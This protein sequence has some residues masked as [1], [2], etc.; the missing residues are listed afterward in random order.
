MLRIPESLHYLVSVRKSGHENSSQL[1]LPSFL[2]T[3][4]TPPSRVPR[5]ETAYML[6]EE[7]FERGF[8]GG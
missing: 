7:H 3:V 6:T 1:V 5:N 4:Y 8:S 2:L